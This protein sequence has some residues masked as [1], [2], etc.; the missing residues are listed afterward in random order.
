ME[1]TKGFLNRVKYTKWVHVLFISSC[2]F[3]LTNSLFF[4][5][6]FFISLNHLSLFVFLISA[7]LMFPS[8]TA[9]MQVIWKQLRQQEVAVFS[10]YFHAYKT[11]FKVAFLSGC[12]N[13]ILLSV[14]IFNYFF[15]KLNPMRNQLWLIPIVLMLFMVVNTSIYQ[16]MIITRFHT[17]FKAVVL[18]SWYYVFKF[19]TETVKNSLLVLIA[20]LSIMILPMS[21]SLLLLSGS[22][23][24]GL[25]V[26][27]QQQILKLEKSV[28][29][30]KNA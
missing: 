25:M 3:L 26:N 6:I 24:L 15:I 11:N 8:I 19:R 29:T 18:L 9:L 28:R 23:A 12:L 4:F 22:L 2:L 5:H 16:A 20:G 17:H 21:L 30:E 14:F 27:M 10:D 1:N 13:V 7:M